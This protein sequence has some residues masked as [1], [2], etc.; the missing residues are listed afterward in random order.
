M[1]NKNT[2]K[3]LTN[4]S[5]PLRGEGGELRETNE[6]GRVRGEDKEK[7][8]MSCMIVK[9][10]KLLQTRSPSPTSYDPPDVTE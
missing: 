10:W 6:I 8:I 7:F 3:K 1:G 4:F 2:Q 9:E 5:S